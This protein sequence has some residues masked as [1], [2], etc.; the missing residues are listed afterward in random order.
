MM[1]KSLVAMVLI[2]GSAPALAAQQIAPVQ[3][4]GSP[5]F[6]MEFDCASP[7]RPSG[8]DV[9]R[10][11]DVRGVSNTHH[12]GTQLMLAVGEACVRGVPAIAVHRTLSGERVAW[13]PLPEQAVSVAK[14]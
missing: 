11:L 2:A 3:V 4:T 6:Q 1:C 13:T 9:T 12:L 7:A 14:N 8:A 10:I 5:D